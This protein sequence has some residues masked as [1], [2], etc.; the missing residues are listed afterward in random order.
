MAT[1][2][3]GSTAISGLGGSD[4]NFD[5]VLQ[6]LKE[7]ESIQV[8]RLEAWKSDW[9]LRY[10][11]FG[12]IIEQVQAAGNVLGTLS[13][14]NN[15]V[16]KNTTSSDQNVVTAVANAS[17]QDV[18]HT[19][20]VSQVASNAIWANTGHVFSTKTDI[21]TSTGGDFTYNY[22]GKDYTVH[23]PQNTTL[24]SFMYMVNNA[25]GNPGV[26][27][28]LIQTGSGYVFQIAGKDTGAANDLYVYSCPGLLGMDASG[29]TSVWQSNA[30]VDPTAAITDPTV[31]T[32]DLVL[33]NGATRSFTI[34]GDSTREQ[35]ASA[36]NAQISGFG[37]AGVDGSGNLALD[38][39]KSVTRKDGSGASAPQ[40]ALVRADTD[41]TFANGHL[42]D[43][44]NNGDVYSLTRIDGTIVTFAYDGVA[45][46]IT[47]DDGVNPPATYTATTKAELLDAVKNTMGGTAST[48]A[49]GDTVLSL[50]NVQDFAQTTGNAGMNGISVATDAETS[51][52]A[53]AFHY[54][55][56]SASYLLEAPPDLV[57]NITLNDGTTLQTTLPS[58]SDMRDVVAGINAAA[59]SNI[60]S[61]VKADGS[62]WSGPADGDAFLRAEDVLAISG[63]GVQGQV[64]SSSNWGIQR[65]ANAV[66]RVDNWPLDM[67]S[68][69]NSVSD[70]I[71]GVVFNIQDVGTARLSVSTD[72]T[73]VEQSI[74]TF[75][76]AVNSV[77]LTVRDLT[78][79]KEDKEV[80]SNDPNDIGKSNYSASLLT[81]EKGALLQGNYGVQLFNSRFKNLLITAPA[82]FKSQQSATDVLSGDLVAKLSDMGIK[83]CTDQNDSN[84]GLFVIAP[85]STIAELTA[86]DMEHYN[87]MISNH[88]QDVVDFF[89]TSGSGAS[90]SADFRY[91]SHI[92]GITKA[93]VY[94]VKYSVD[95]NGNITGVTVGGVEAKR[96]T[97]MPGY[98]FSVAEGSA[99]GL[100]IVIDD[101]T[102]GDHTGQVRIKE[103]MVQTVQNFLKAEL[104][105]TDVTVSA[106]NADAIALK[107]ENGALMVLRDNYKK[108][109]ENID[110]KIALEETRLAMWESRQKRIFAN[111]ETMLKQYNE[112]LAT[113]ES[114][115][116]QLESD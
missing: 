45:N 27:V 43:A 10:Q 78:S 96:D 23:V 59:G 105:F 11:A 64:I 109:M 108:I 1:T 46:E 42:G 50:V 75:L 54:D 113:L 4:T 14:R 60:A 71:E 89:C 90:T 70:V 34:R 33:E 74:Q 57:Y 98:Y 85:N 61:L 102:P 2:I 115:L 83:I 77:L 40:G 76:D 22:A 52:D 100:S 114:Q 67:E 19:I 80:T 35:L 111:L 44:L 16:T 12:Q 68:A 63:P 106:D 51:I 6:Q 49:N 95:A 69:S 65:A 21:I 39:V 8:N 101:L 29:A 24:E 17:A 15:F 86:M 31:Y 62:A 107:S 103:G 97:S 79:F 41:L 56:A 25:T 37:S 81:S 28:S 53:G 32:Y 7:V 94:D 38:G 84:Y 13:N 116:S 48:D 82:G 30:A 58:G 3:S 36:I 20:A 47:A 55:V 9:S 92:E 66:Y 112:Q 26:Q 99:R 88:L 110:K 73:S 91:G 5:L 104:Q 72:I 87:D 93:G 18:Q